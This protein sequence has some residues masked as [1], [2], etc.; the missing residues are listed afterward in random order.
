MK[1][2]VA[3]PACQIHC[4]VTVLQIGYTGLLIEKKEK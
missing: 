2:A 4:K 1:T 3:Y